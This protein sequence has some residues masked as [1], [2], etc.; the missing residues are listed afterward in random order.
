MK[1]ISIP[2]NDTDEFDKMMYIQLLEDKIEK[3][4]S[5]VETLNK[6]VFSLAARDFPMSEE[7]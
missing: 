5:N 3:L 7:E 2:W 6:I 4:E 1:D